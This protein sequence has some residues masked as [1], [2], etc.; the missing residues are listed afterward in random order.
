VANRSDCAEACRVFNMGLVVY[1]DRDNLER[2]L[3]HLES[4]HPK[5]IGEVKER[6]FVIVNGIKLIFLH[7]FEEKKLGFRLPIFRPYFDT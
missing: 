7:N 1:T 4:H 6:E 2:A 3:V 5:P